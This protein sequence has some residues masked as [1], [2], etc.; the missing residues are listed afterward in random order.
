MLYSRIT[1]FPPICRKNRSFF[2]KGIRFV[3]V[4][5][6]CTNYLSGGF[7][8]NVKPVA[9]RVTIVPSC[10]ACSTF[11][12]RRSFENFLGT[13]VGLAIRFVPDGNYDLKICISLDFVK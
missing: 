9:A 4:P 6:C 5:L 2:N 8:N 1:A 7:V 10:L 13:V 11:R 12:L 3:Y